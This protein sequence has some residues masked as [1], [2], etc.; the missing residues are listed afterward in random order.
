MGWWIMEVGKKAGKIIRTSQE[1]LVPY[2]WPGLMVGVDNG[3][4]NLGI[5]SNNNISK[6]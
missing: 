6:Q 2:E 5:G 4:S 1:I 3:E